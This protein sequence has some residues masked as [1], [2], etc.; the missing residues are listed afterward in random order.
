VSV[1]RWTAASPTPIALPP[2]RDLR[3][4]LLAMVG[5][6]R[7]GENVLSEED[8]GRGIQMDSVGIR[9]ARAA[10]SVSSHMNR[11]PIGRRS[12]PPQRH[13]GERASGAG[14]SQATRRRP[15]F[16]V[17]ESKMNVTFATQLSAT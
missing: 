16:P 4:Q 1:I 3:C 7:L 13:T 17:S 15:A 9:A 11:K 6:H 5:A 14:V 12:S 8:P 10:A 2:A